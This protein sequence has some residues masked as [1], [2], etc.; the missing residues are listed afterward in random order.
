VVLYKISLWGY[1]FILKDYL[2][3]ARK[4]YRHALKFN[5]GVFNYND[6]KKSELIKAL[7]LIVRF[8][9]WPVSK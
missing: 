6:K 2:Q 7:P 8:L 3:N 4:T 9:W 1:A 5:Y